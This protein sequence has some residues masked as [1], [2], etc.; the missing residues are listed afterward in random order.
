MDAHVTY[1]TIN[2]HSYT[3]IQTRAEIIL[4]VCLLVL[5]F[6]DYH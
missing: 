3:L 6:H 4:D 1:I 2:V 5:I